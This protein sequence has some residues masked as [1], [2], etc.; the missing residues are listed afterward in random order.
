M[1]LEYIQDN[2]KDFVYLAIDT[3]DNQVHY[4]VRTYFL[5]FFL[6][7]K[8]ETVK[9]QTAQFLETLCDHIDGSLTFTAVFCFAA[10]E[11]SLLSNNTE[12]IPTKFGVLSDYTDCIFITKTTPITRVETCLLIT[13]MLSYAL[14]LRN[15][16]L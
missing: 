1:E 3:C 8:S 12:E 4:T 2:P 16:L 10:L 11:Y 5:I 9:T 15:D 6:P 13:A 14:P 7:Q